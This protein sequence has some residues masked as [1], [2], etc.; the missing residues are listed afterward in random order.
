MRLIGPIGILLA[1]VFSVLFT[2]WNGTQRVT[3]D[4]GLF[5]LFRVPVVFLAFGGMVFGMFVMLIAGLDSDLRV[6]QIL[7]DRLKDEDREEKERFIDLD[8]HDLF[9]QDD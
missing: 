4:L 7:R 1:V 9:E 3:V 8:Q 5:T 2:A 6:R